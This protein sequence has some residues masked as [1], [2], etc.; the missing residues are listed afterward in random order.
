MTNPNVV[1]SSPAR[2]NPNQPDEGQR[3]QPVPDTEINPAAPG[4]GT[5]VDLDK[6]KISTYPDQNPPERQ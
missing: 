1:P 4:T 6:S 3:L 5:E 2:P